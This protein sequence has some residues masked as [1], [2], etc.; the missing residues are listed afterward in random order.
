MVFTIFTFCVT[1]TTLSE[2]GIDS[3]VAV[4]VK[5]S[6]ERELG[7]QIPLEGLRFM[8]I[9]KLLELA[10]VMEPSSGHSETMEDPNKIVM[11]E[12]HVPIEYFHQTIVRIPSLNNDADISSCILIIPGAEGLLSSDYSQ[13]CSFLNWPTFILPLFNTWACRD[14]QEIAQLVFEVRTTIFWRNDSWPKFRYFFEIF[15]WTSL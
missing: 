12:F 6:L 4:E 9:P 1:E 10:D 11:A 8:T 2:F 13:M 5:Q 15:A 7:I 3:I 14:V